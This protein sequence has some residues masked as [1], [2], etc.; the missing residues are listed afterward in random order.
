M[1]PVLIPIAA[2]ALTGAVGVGVFGVSA[3]AAILSVAATA[4]ASG[5]SYLTAPSAGRSRV[6]NAAQISAPGNQER[7]V[8][9]S[10]PIPPRRFAYGTFRTGGT[11]FF[12]DNAN[13]NLC[14]GMALSDGVIESVDAVYYG[15]TIIPVDGSG[16]ATPATIYSDHFTR[17]WTPG[18]DSQTASPLLLANFPTLGSDFC[19][20]GVARLVVQMDWGADATDHNSLWG[21]SISPSAFGRWLRV[22]DPRDISQDKHDASTW[23]FSDNPVLHTAHALTSAWGVALDT[24]DD[25]D[26][27]MIATAADIC[28][29]PVTVGDQ[30]LP[31]F[32]GAGVFEAGTNFGSQIADML[33]AY[34]GKIVWSAGKYGI[35]ADIARGSVWTVTEDDLIELGEW[36]SGAENGAA[37]ASVSAHFFDV[38]SNG[39]Q[40]AT[41][42]V[43]KLAD[44]IAEEGDRRL[45][46]TL[47]FTPDKHSAQI[48]A[49]RE[50]LQTR[51]GRSLTLT[52]SDAAVYL[53]PS[54]VITLDFQSAAFLN[55]DY[56]VMQVDVAAFGVTLTLRGYSPAVYADPST[57]L[58]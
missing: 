29:R 36:A 30:T 27:A 40:M 7:S 12:E 16:A 34:R 58:A 44:V 42:P 32:R 26:W 2:A 8:P 11:L 37:F 56:E 13:P 55:G 25:I 5:V 22:Y 52:L 48:I 35:I 18:L 50:L 47:P 21:D 57:Y 38:T 17:E 45:V 41:T 1:P 28:D 51:D 54:E 4:L 46:P 14:V 9:I 6:V 39:G 19:Q 15:D 53:V 43:Y 10:Q 33:T 23:K 24:D 31:M 20:K 3:T 49:Y